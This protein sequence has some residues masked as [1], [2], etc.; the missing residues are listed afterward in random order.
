[1]LN[2][3]ITVMRWTWRRSGYCRS[4]RTNK[5]RL[6]DGRNKRLYHATLERD[7]ESAAFRGRLSRGRG[8]RREVESLLAYRGSEDFI[9]SRLADLRTPIEALRRRGQSP[10]NRR[11]RLR[12][13][14]IKSWIAAIG[15]GEVY[16]AIDTRLNP[17]SPS[18][19]ARTLINDAD[20]QQR[21]DAKRTL[22]QRIIRTSAHS[23]TQASRM[24]SII[25]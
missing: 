25:W 10:D 7:G 5:R 14:R 8:L 1:M 19:P 21:W 3:S 16:R 6:N 9:E 23:T 13:L 18:D 22:F 24:A 2:V 20:R 11:T 15:M 17:P 12:R 4:C